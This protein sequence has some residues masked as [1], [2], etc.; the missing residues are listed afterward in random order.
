[1][2]SRGR[3]TRDENPQG[4]LEDATRVEEQRRAASRAFRTHA[5][6]Q[7]RVVVCCWLAILWSGARCLRLAASSGTLSPTA[8][9]RNSAAAAAGHCSCSVCAPYSCLEMLKTTSISDSTRQGRGAG[10]RR[11]SVRERQHQPGWQKIVKSRSDQAAQKEC[12]PMELHNEC[13]TQSTY[14]Q[15]FVIYKTNC[16]RSVSF[17]LV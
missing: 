17:S 8:P 13:N 4:G 16:L 10:R 2:D 7:L 12:R 1:M 15:H 5:T 11:S 6:A 9:S 3:N 14:T